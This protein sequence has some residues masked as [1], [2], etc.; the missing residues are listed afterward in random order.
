MRWAGRSESGEVMMAGLVE[1]GLSSRGHVSSKKRLISIVA[2]AAVMTI[3][4]VENC[5]FLN[6]KFHSSKLIGRTPT[7]IIQQLGSPSYDGRYQPPDNPVVFA[8]RDWFGN[9]CIIRFES[10]VSVSVEFKAK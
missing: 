7:Q 1:T 5:V 2:V 10:G 9:I 4:F 8:Y 6:P 3:A